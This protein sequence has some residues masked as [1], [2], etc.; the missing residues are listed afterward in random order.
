VIFTCTEIGRQRW[1][2]PLHVEYA[3][4]GIEYGILFIFSLF[5][6]YIHL[7][8]MVIYR[9]DQAEY[10]THMLAVAPQEYVNSYSTRRVLP[11]HCIL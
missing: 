10:L 8:Y 7:E 9:V 4:R 3:E 6:E 2:F 5:C 11:L 1:V